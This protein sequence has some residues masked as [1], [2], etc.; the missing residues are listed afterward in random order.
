MIFVYYIVRLHAMHYP[1]DEYFLE[2]LG[3]SIKQAYRSISS[4]VS[5]P[6]FTMGIRFALLHILEKHAVL[7]HPLYIAVLDFGSKSYA[8]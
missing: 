1:A 5:F 4:Q 7:K 2:H 3:C 6:G 8:R